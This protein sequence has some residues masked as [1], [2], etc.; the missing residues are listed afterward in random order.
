MKNKNNINIV[1]G[2]GVSV[3]FVLDAFLDSTVVAI[4]R[5]DE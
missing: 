1:H 4:L 3:Y 2:V 5:I